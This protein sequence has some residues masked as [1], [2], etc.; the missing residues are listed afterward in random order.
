MKSLDPD[1]LQ[2]SFSLKGAKVAVLGYDADAR[3][4]AFA[5]RAAN[6]SVS[7]GVRADTPCWL[8]ASAD[9]FAVGRPTE[10]VEGAEIVVVLV[11]EPEKTWRR[12]EPYV[13]PGALVVFGCAR[14]LEAG[15]VTRGGFDAALVTTVDDA[16]TGCRIAV[17]RDATTRAL[18]RAVAYA[19][20]ACGKDVALRLT[21]VEAEA[22]LELASISERAGS[23][24]AL[25]ASCECLPVAAAKPQAVIVENEEVE[26]EPTWFDSMLAWRSRM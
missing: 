11:R 24:L 3:D 7:I 25:T 5:L 9:G 13:A 2:S 26:R 15:I 20:A 14:L 21:S 16:H 4:H 19:R 18:L 12:I 8:R 10:V 22:D 1:P 17:H 6:N 23:L